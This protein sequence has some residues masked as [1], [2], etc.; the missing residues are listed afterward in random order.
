MITVLRS[1]PECGCNDDGK[2]TCMRQLDVDL[3]DVKPDECA[4]L[5][6]HDREIVLNHICAELARDTT[7]WF[8]ATASVDAD[9]KRLRPLVSQADYE[10]EP[11]TIDPQRAAAKAAIENL[12]LGATPE[13]VEAAGRLLLEL[14]PG[15]PARTLPGLPA[16][17]MRRARAMAIEDGARRA[18]IDR[19]EAA[20]TAVRALAGVTDI[21]C[22]TAVKALLAYAPDAAPHDLPSLAKHFLGVVRDEA[23]T[24][25]A[26]RPEPEDVAYR[27][28]VEA[29][30]TKSQRRVARARWAVRTRRAG[31]MR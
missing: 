21:E 12:L 3:D 6:V 7:G 19:I 16:Y 22:E 10:V 14:A 27:T 24:A 8:Y 26:F 29:E 17:A 28:D 20:T 18:L 30:I 2:C 25:R 1:N 23:E 11:N 4:R 15:F 5:S 13:E 9:N 31:G